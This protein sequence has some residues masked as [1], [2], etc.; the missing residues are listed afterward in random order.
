M[1][2]PNTPTRSKPL[3]VKQTSIPARRRMNLCSPVAAPHPNL[4]PG[5]KDRRQGEGISCVP[6]DAPIGVKDG[7][8][9]KADRHPTDSPLP[10]IVQTILGRGRV[11]GPTAS[12]AKNLAG[13][14]GVYPILPADGSNSRPRRPSFWSSPRR[15]KSPPGRRNFPPASILSQPA[16]ALHLFTSLF[17]GYDVVLIGHLVSVALCYAAS[18]YPLRSGSFAFSSKASPERGTG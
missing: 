6:A 7:A 14:I 4:L 11:R 9:Q 12:P 5:G 3:R 10:K 1:R 13:N 15:Q 18:F 16:E 8:V 2:G 17:G